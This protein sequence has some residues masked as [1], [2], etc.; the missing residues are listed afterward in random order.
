LLHF[1][2]FAWHEGRKPNR[3]FDPTWY[4]EHQSDV[5]EAGMSPLLHCV[6]HGN[7]EGHWPIRHFDPVW[8]RTAH[9]LLPEALR[10]RISSR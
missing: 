10:W 9:D 7:H 4:L 8:Y 6:R 3:Y 1:I 5:H 2:R